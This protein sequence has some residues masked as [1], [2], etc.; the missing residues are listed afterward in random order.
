MKARG[1]IFREVGT[2][3]TI[4]EVDIADPLPNEVLVR[5]LACGVCHSDLHFVN[6]SIGGPAPT[7]P[8]HEPAGIVEAVGSEVRTV[9]VGD[10]VIACTSM[11]CGQ[12]IQCMKGRPYLCVDRGAT[13][14]KRGEVPRISQNGRGLFQ[15]ADLSG[16]CEMMLVHE[17]AVVKIGN[18]IPIDRAALVGCAVTTGVGAALNTAKVEPGSTV[19]VFGAGGVGSSI[20]QG[21]R[22]A[23]ARQIIAIDVVPHKLETAKTFGATDVVLSGPDSPDGDPIKAIKK[24]SKGG[25]DYAF[26]AV[27][28]T[29]LSQQCFYSLAPKGTA[30]IVGAIPPGQKLELEPG[31]FFVEKTITGCFMGSNRFHID[32]L[33]YLE[34]Y[35]QGRLDLDTM[36]SERM[37]LGDINKAFELMENGEVTRSVLTFD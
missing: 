30:V 23:G 28:M 1:A 25:V 10:H 24:L 4:E 15:F 13:R 9:E 14:R 29:L 32:A 12:C 5:T 2:P 26:D 27:G 20:I 35:R 37:P 8:G 17:R 19:A 33:N 3:L 21:A 36:I 6:G 34:L 11:F 22:I 16:F 7:I 31:H 18:D